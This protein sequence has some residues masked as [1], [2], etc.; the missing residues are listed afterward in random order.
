[1]GKKQKQLLLMDQE[2]FIVKEW[3]L[4]LAILFPELPLFLVDFNN[5]LGIVLQFI[6]VLL[7]FSNKYTGFVVLFTI[8][9][10]LFIAVYP[11]IT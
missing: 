8:G 1:M 5:K 6:G 7:V 2:M 9:W 11:S 10:I 4:K 3:N